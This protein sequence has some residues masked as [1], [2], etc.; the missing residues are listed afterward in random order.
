[1]WMRQ[2][3]PTGEQLA[4]AISLIGSSIE[5]EKSDAMFYEWLLITF[6]II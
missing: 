1:M 2:S 5:N 3:Y 4:N 6:P